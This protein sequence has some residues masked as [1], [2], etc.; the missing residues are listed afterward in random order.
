MWSK[1]FCLTF[2]L[3]FFFFFLL[4]VCFFFFGCISL[5][6]G[7][8]FFEFVFFWSFFTF[9]FVVVLLRVSLFVLVFSRFYSGRELEF[10]W[11][12]SCLVS[13]IFSMLVFLLGK[14]WF[15]VFLGWEG[16]GF[17]SLLLISFFSSFYRRRSSL[18][19]AFMNRVGDLFLLV[20]GVLL[21]R[22]GNRVVGVLLLIFRALAKSA[23][24]PFFSWLPSAMAAPTPVSALVHS[25]TLVT[26]GVWLLFSS[27]VDV[28]LVAFV[29]F[30]SS[31]V[32]GVMAV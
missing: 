29:G 32:G 3:S 8:F 22:R 13:F 30:V 7:S 6:F 10:F 25:S 27:G 11:F 12:V 15:I 21:I 4:L 17:T 28:F 14:R 5:S 24:F 18:K 2:F 31:L 19:T 26:A 9:L 16:L 23:Q 20:A 1:G